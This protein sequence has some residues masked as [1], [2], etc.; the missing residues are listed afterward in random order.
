[1]DNKTDRRNQDGGIKVINDGENNE[2]EKHKIE[3]KRQ[4]EDTVKKT[5]DKRKKRKGGK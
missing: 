3:E 1:M 2:K 4:K 5:R